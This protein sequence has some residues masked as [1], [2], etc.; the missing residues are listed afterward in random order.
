M[1]RTSVILTLTCKHCGSQWTYSF[2][3]TD[4]ARFKK[5]GWLDQQV[6][7]EQKCLDAHQIELE[8]KVKNM[9]FCDAL[10]GQ[11]VN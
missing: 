9:V 10:T 1:A 5:Y 2:T 11:E 7:K 6:C 3:K 8:E 4:A